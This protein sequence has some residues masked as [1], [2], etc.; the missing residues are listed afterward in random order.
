M[1]SA[2]SIGDVLA[3]SRRS[4]GGIMARFHNILVAVDFSETSEDA[5]S[6]AAELSHAYHAPVHLLHVVPKAQT[7]YAMEPVAF[8]VNAYLRERLEAVRAQMPALAARCP[9]E[10]AMLTTAVLQG[11]PA[12][13]IVRYAE[14]HAIDLIVLGA[15]GHGFLDRLLIGSVAERVARHAP[16]A[17][18][19]VPHVTRRPTSFEVKAAAGVGS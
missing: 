5:V 16:C 18:L 7:P 3:Q 1:R 15:H 8:D 13:E 6:V 11:T 2:A 9:I 4:R 17:I 14:E 12:G 19:M 10:P